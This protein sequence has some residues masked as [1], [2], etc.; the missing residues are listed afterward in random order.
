MGMGEGGEPDPHQ[1]AVR[2][3]ATPLLRIILFPFLFFRATRS[4]D[5]L[6]GS[7]LAA[8][9][10]GKSCLPWLQREHIAANII[11]KAI[12]IVNCE[13]SR[14]PYRDLRFRLFA[15]TGFSIARSQLRQSVEPVWTKLL[16]TSFILVFAY[17][18]VH[19]QDNLLDF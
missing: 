7:L 17:S 14:L 19:R 10:I 6:R 12:F 8:F 16:S 18:E 3:V 4:R 9:A 1:S 2:A 11:N 5:A 13:P 15:A